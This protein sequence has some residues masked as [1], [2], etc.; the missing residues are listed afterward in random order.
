MLLTFI[1]TL[2]EPVNKSVGDPESVLFSIFGYG[3]I[4]CRPQ[5]SGITSGARACVAL[6]IELGDPIC[7]A[8][9]SVL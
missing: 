4:S 2:C 3:A 7:K 5:G 8:H 1:H 9:I 6:E